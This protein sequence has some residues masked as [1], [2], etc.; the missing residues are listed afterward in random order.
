MFGKASRRFDAYFIALLAMCAAF[1]A[2]WAGYANYRYTSLMSS[3][4]DLGQETY[5][6]YIHLH[7]PS[8]IYGLQFLS[9]S[10]HISLFKIALLPIFALYQNPMTL[11]LIQ[12][13]LLALCAIVIY[14]IGKKVA[15]NKLLGFVI[16]VAFLINPGVRGLSA[17]DLHAEAAIPLFLLLA[18]YFYMRGEK[19]QFVA[20]YA[21]MMSTMEAA[22]V[23]GVSLILGLFFYEKFYALKKKSNG[24]SESRKRMRTLLIALG[25]TV[26][27]VLF[28]LYVITSLTSAYASGGYTVMP[29]FLKLVNFLAVQTTALGNIAAVQYNPGQLIFVFILGFVTL[30]LG[31]GVTTFRNVALT[32]ILVLP[33]LLELVV[34]HNVVFGTLNN[35]YYAFV[36]GG[37]VVAA[38]LGFMIVTAEKRKRVFGININQLLPFTLSLSIMIS[39]ILLP[40]GFGNPLSFFP[41]YWQQTGNYSA[42]QNALMAIPSNSSVL[43]QP[44]LSAHLYNVLYLELPPYYQVNAYTPSGF[45]RLNITTYYNSRPQ[46]VAIDSNLADFNITMSNS[47]FNV[48]EFMGSNYT[49]YLSEGGV[50]IYKLG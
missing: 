27:F 28:Y 6:M 7:N 44:L 42:I 11:V 41:G 36:V 30:F 38:I 2:Y 9:F 16:A 46:Y 39:V 48:Y 18:F 10:N 23:A 17:Y 29:P 15:E 25:V 5:S 3:F 26:G 4:W 32:S 43:T 45:G 37:A 14:F 8:L 20:S 34:L 1:V 47:Q 12:S 33:W 31:F 19:W 40:L 49:K 24:V 22:P 35:Q 21:I 13:I 50:E